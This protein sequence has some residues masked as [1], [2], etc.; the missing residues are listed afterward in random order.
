MPQLIWKNKFDYN[1]VT[2]WKFQDFLERELKYT[3]ITYKRAA[4]D[5]EAMC[6]A[7]KLKE[8]KDDM[9]VIL[10]VKIVLQKINP[11]LVS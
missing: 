5:W 7:I 2:N 6:A 1:S 9:T 4:A 8:L 11:A 3:E 10:K